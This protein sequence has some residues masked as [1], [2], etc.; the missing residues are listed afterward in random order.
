MK[1]N[2]DEIKEIS[3][4]TRTKRIVSIKLYCYKCDKAFIHFDSYG[5]YELLNKKYKSFVSCPYCNDF[6]RIMFYEE[7]NCEL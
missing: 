4:A 3:I 2:F 6:E 7:V 1:F 5:S